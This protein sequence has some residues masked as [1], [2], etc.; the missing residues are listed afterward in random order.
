M[1][2]NLLFNFKLNKSSHA[3]RLLISAVILFSSLLIETVSSQAA[4]VD[5]RIENF[6]YNDPKPE[7]TVYLTF[8]DGPS[9]YTLEILNLLEELDVP[10]IF[11]VIGENLEIVP[12]A[13]ESL[14]E[15]IHRGH[16]IGLHS[17]TH[18]MDKLYNAPDAPQ[19]FVNEM[20]EVRD[21]IKELTG[22]FESHLC[23][24]PYG[25]KTHFKPGHYKALEEAGIECVDWNVDSL[26]W[27]KSS[28]DQIFNQVVSDLKRSQYPNEVVL[29]FHEKK[30][31]LEVLP[32]VIEYYRDLGYVFMPYY[33]GQEFDCLK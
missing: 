23:R 13:E 20:L 15:V 8:D 24:P 26:D 28:A 19:N 21:K 22:G 29:L 6:I 33:E 27:A 31:T 14:K 18:D 1:M 2:R 4:T 17:M 7:K 12:N 5:D 3:V 25:G 30:L 16:Y 32:R 10:A 9:S 11:F